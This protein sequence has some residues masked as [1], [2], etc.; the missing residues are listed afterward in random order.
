[1]EPLNSFERI[2]ISSAG[3]NYTIAPDLNVLDGFT[4]KKIKEVDLTY[5]IGDPT[6]TILKNTKS[7]NNIKPIIIPTSNVNGIDIKTLSYYVSTKNVT[8]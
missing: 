3:K 8:I 6:V 1:M 5:K 4:K 7:L 2:G